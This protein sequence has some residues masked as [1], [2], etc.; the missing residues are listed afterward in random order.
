M[1]EGDE[2][3]TPHLVREQLGIVVTIVVTIVARRPLTDGTRAPWH[4]ACGHQACRVRRDAALGSGAS[5]VFDADAWLFASELVG[6]GG[7]RE[8]GLGARE[9]PRGGGGDECWW[10]RSPSTTMRSES[11]TAA[12]HHTNALS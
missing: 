6:Q 5:G 3:S 9:G 2:F 11:V 8:D 1:Y 10:R 7:C 12:S 4:Q